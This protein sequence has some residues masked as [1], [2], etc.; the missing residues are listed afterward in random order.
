MQ[1][2]KIEKISSEEAKKLGIDSWS[3]WECEPSKFDWEYPEEET[4]YVFEGDVI[5]TAYGEETQITGNMLVTFPKGMKCTW[6]VR[7]T[8]RKVYTFN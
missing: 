5:V 4:A 8:I 6:D 7:K 3:Q 1:K 2:I